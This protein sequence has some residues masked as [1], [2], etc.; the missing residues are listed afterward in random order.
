MIIDFGLNPPYQLGA[1][2]IFSRMKIYKLIYVYNNLLKIYYKKL[3]KLKE[4]LILH[5]KANSS[6]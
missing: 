5:L 4:A 2:W 3:K 1:R 6:L